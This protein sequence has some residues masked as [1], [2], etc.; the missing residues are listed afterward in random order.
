MTSPIVYYTT[1]LNILGDTNTKEIYASIIN[2]L[3]F[4]NYHNHLNLYFHT[5]HNATTYE[6][7]FSYTTTPIPKPDNIKLSNPFLN[8]NKHRIATIHRLQQHKP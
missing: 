3:T 1:N 4:S 2:K 6:K 7:K 8:I 5:M